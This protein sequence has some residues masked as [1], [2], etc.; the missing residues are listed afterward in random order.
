MGEIWERNFAGRIFRSYLTSSRRPYHYRER[1]FAFTYEQ[2]LPVR[3][4]SLNLPVRRGWFL[5]IPLPALLLP[6]SESREY[7][8]G[9][10]FHFD[11]G[12]YA[13]LRGGLIVR[14]RGSVTPDGEQASEPTARPWEQVV[15]GA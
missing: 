12:L 6:A 4:Q 15:K 14:Y 13:P 3:D 10:I 8:V 5:G 9:G 11:V 2:E 7:A 1:F